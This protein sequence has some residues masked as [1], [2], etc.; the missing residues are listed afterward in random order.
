VLPLGALQ[1]AGEFFLDHEQPLVCHALVNRFLPAVCFALNNGVM[2]SP[3]QT[4]AG[5]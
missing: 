1:H 3:N 5:A 2:D 4:F